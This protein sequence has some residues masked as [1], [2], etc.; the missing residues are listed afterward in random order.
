MHRSKYWKILNFGSAKLVLAV[1]DD[2]PINNLGDITDGALVATEFPNLTSRY[3]K[4][5][6]INAKIVELSGSTEIAPFIGV[7][8]II[9]N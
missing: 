6:G 3:L 7:A 8:D 4:T 1:P 9:A 2:S 5:N